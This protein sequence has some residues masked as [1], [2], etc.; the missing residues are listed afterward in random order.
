MTGMVREKE[1]R[2]VTSYRYNIG[3]YFKQAEWPKLQEPPSDFSS[4]LPS[5]SSMPINGGA[6][7][8]LHT[9]KQT[10]N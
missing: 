6:V 7:E 4:L 8:L 9:Y 2:R 10:R 3:N 1:E 5:F